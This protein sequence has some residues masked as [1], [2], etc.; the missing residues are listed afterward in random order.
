ML[1]FWPQIQTRDALSQYAGES[2]LRSLADEALATV[3]RIATSRQTRRPSLE[4]AFSPSPTT[5]TAI[6]AAKS[7]QMMVQEAAA[8]AIK[9]T[10]ETMP[11]VLSERTFA[12]EAAK[13]LSRRTWSN[14]SASSSPGAL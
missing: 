5:S 11:V 4:G 8:A 2:S 14:V 3:K 6:A 7:R 12:H 9:K 13:T 1:T 10:G